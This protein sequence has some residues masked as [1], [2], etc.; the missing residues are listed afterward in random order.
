MATWREV[1]RE[2]WVEAVYCGA[3]LNCMALALS[4]RP[5]ALPWGLWAV[6]VVVGAAIFTAAAVQALV[7]RARWRA[8]VRSRRFPYAASPDEFDQVAAVAEARG[9][10]DGA[11]EAR[12]I[13]RSLRAVVAQVEAQS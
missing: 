11:R 10:L 12:R 7:W 1:L 13:A 9:E 4:Y 8:A 2:R 3:S 6:V 5:R